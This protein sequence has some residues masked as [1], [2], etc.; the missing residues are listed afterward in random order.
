VV[1]IDPRIRGTVE[2]LVIEAE[3]RGDEYLFGN[4]RSM[5]RAFRDHMILLGYIGRS[6]PHVLRHSRATHLLQDGVPI[7]DVARLLG[8]TVATVERVYG[9]HS[10]DHLAATLGRAAG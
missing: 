10:A 4:N 7:F 6:H 8:D 3:A 5:Y 9:H 2:R 1:P